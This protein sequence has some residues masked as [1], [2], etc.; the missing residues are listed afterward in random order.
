M[1]EEAV[2]ETDFGLGKV[3]NPAVDTRFQKVD[4]GENHLIVKSPQLRQESLNKRKRG[5]VL[6]GLQL[7]SP[8]NGAKR[9]GG[10]NAGWTHKLMRRVSRLCFRNMRFSR[11]AHSMLSL[12]TVI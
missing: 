11:L 7:S 12:R 2:K 9:P 5:F 8:H 4:F 1:I 10:S 3:T 6:L